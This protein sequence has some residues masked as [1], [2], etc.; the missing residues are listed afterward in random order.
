MDSTE[1]LVAMIRET[2]E[3]YDKTYVR[4]AAGEVDKAMSEWKEDI[5]RGKLRMEDDK[6]PEWLNEEERNAFDDIRG[7]AKRFGAECLMMYPDTKT[8]YIITPEEIAI[9]E[10]LPII[11]RFV[12]EKPLTLD[13]IEIPNLTSEEK[14]EGWFYRIG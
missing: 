11:D 3:T 7:I 1:K 5:A 10:I 12:R 4:L 8:V 14:Y 9:D 6:Y 13:H 2:I